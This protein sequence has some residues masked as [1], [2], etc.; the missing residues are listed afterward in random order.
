MASIYSTRLADANIAGAGS[1]VAYT[2]PAI[3]TIV[4]RT[5]TIVAFAT[6]T[7][8][9]IYRTASVAYLAAIYPVPAGGMAEV[10]NGRWVLNPGETLTYQFL[11]GGGT[12]SIHGYTL[13][14]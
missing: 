12:Y 4:V 3:N 5:I 11:V 9:A 14:P 10:F 13:T 7:L 6:T 8:A 1:G 2:A